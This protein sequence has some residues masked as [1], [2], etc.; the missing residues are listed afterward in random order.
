[1]VWFAIAAH[2]GA[3]WAAVEL[4]GVGIYGYA[5]VRGFR[6]SA[7][8]LVAGWA[9]HP[10]W[11]VALHYAGPGRSLAP[12]W[13]TTSCLTYDLIVAGTATIAILIGTHLT[14]SPARK[15]TRKLK[16]SLRLSPCT[17]VDCIAAGARAA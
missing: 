8:W 1:Y 16:S 17:C 6:G 5:A 4:T 13:Y 12:A 11:D 9:L 14:D 10:I 2:T 3:V 7:W 15:P